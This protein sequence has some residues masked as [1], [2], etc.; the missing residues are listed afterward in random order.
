V[1]RIRAFHFST[2]YV[3]EKYTIL[4]WLGKKPQAKG[5]IISYIPECKILHYTNIVLNIGLKM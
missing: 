2:D 5:V 3:C 1:A 4:Q